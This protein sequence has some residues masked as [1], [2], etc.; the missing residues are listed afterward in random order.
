[1]IKSISIL[2]NIRS[3]EIH[4]DFNDFLRHNIPTT[5]T[6]GRT[7]RRRRDRRDPIPLDI[8]DADKYSRTSTQRQYRK[9]RP[10]IPYIEKYPENSKYSEKYADKYSFI[11]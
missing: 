2:F 11:F 9:I 8:F 7:Y 10:E 6:L 5:Y 1:M 3:P 4:H